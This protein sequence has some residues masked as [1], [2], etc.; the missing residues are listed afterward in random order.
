[1]PAYDESLFDPS[2]PLARVTLRDPQKGA[3]VSDVPMLLDSG[4]DVTLIPEASVNR[5]GVDTSSHESYELRG[6]NGHTSSCP[7]SK[8]GEGM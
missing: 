7:L 4:A 3:L 6:F 8:G 1:M 2:V 5:V